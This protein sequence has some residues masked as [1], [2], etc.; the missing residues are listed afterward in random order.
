MD[1]LSGLQVYSPSTLIPVMS[2][3]EEGPLRSLN[4]AW[5]LHD[6]SAL[7]VDA[8]LRAYVDMGQ[9]NRW[10][11]FSFFFLFLKSSSG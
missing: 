8:E 10:I 3:H 2:M 1:N 5:N 4:E 6:N 7:G 11:F 9:E